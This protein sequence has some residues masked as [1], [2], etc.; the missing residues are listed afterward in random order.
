MNNE[1]PST[2]KSN[3]AAHHGTEPSTNLPPD[4]RQTEPSGAADTT[5]LASD[6]ISS[7]A[8]GALEQYRLD[9]EPA[10]IEAVRVAQAVA[11]RPSADEYFRAHPEIGL[12]VRTVENSRLRI[13]YLVARAAI[14]AVRMKLRDRR[15]VLCVNVFGDFFVWPVSLPGASGSPNPW[16]TSAHRALQIAKTDWVRI[17]AGNG[18]Y[19]IERP[20]A[21][22]TLPR[23]VKW[24]EAPFG[25]LINSAYA[26]RI[27][28]GPDHP[29]IAELRGKI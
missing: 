23:E 21:D 29:M 4:T 1:N 3:G 25:E 12:N 20:A 19:E 27:I 8:L 10:D 24:P 16:I 7:T 28:T 9:P 17:F 6:T 15:L 11:R 13:E 22:H 5:A 18:F 14:G 26:G 2:N